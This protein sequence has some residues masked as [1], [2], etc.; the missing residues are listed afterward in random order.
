MSISFFVRC[1]KAGL[2]LLNGQTVTIH[3]NDLMDLNTT[4]VDVIQEIQC[5]IGPYL[6]QYNEAERQVYA[7]RVSGTS[8][9]RLKLSR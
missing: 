7:D 8:G 5:F 3:Y 1:S 4:L 6:A 9:Y 2:S